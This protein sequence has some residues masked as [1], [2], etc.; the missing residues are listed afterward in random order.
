MFSAVSLVYTLNIQLL[1]PVSRFP[2]S[3]W[4]CPRHRFVLYFSTFQL[5]VKSFNWDEINTY[6]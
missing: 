4:L 6:E 2:L 3:E 5:S 1:A